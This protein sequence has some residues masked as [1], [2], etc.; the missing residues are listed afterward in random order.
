M[1]PHLL[2][3]AVI[4]AFVFA[5][6]FT[7]DLR[8]GQSNITPDKGLS[9]LVPPSDPSNGDPTLGGCN[10]RGVLNMTFH[11][12]SRRS[13]SIL[14]TFDESTQWSFD[15]GDSVTNNGNGND[16]GSQQ[17]D[18]EVHGN[19]KDLTIAGSDKVEN[20]GSYGVLHK[21]KGFLTGNVT[22]VVANQRFEATSG[23][24]FLY[25]NSFKLFALRGQEDREGDVNYDVFFGMNRV[26]ADDEDRVGS[27]LCR[28][29]I[30]MNS[31]G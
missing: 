26:I 15:I 11:K 22:A 1:G 28:V 17:R 6:D 14:M 25:F 20:N 19:N 24:R 5:A 21:S 18:A 30:T 3:L 31:R 12:K 13:A 9:W 7:V 23:N 10:W 29:E 8:T 16:A 4:P 27:G 2:F